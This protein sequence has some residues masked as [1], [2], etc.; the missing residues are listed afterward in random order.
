[1]HFLPRKKYPRRKWWEQWTWSRWLHTHVLYVDEMCCFRAMQRG[2]RLPPKWVVRF[3]YL[4]FELLRVGWDTY[5]V[6]Y[7][8]KYIGHDWVDCSWC[9]PDSGGDGGY[10]RRCGWGFTHTYY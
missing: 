9:T 2:R 1:M 5:F 8:G 10:C 6:W 7:C 4:P 3:I